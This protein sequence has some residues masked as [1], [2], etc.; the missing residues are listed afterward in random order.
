MEELLCF[1]IQDQ[2]RNCRIDWYLSGQM[3]EY[4]R[5]FIQKLLKDGKV[6]V[7]GKPVKASY[8]VQ[9]GE[10]VEA[11]IPEPE[12]RRSF[13]KTSRWIFCTRMRMC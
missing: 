13:R 7:S 12:I 1:E 11:L 9:P 4:S 3:E 5:S 8:K 2:D 10:R 6:S